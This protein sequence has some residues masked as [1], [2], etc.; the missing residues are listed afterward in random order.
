VAP[1]EPTPGPR[2]AR[3]LDKGHGRLEHR[4]LES[5]P[6]LTVQQKWPGLQQGFRVRRWGIR[7]G[8][9]YEEVV[10]GITSLAPEKADAERL[11]ELV[12]DHWRI[13]NSLHYI[14]DVTLGEDACQVRGDTAPQVLAALRNVAVHLL[15]QVDT[16]NHAQATRRLAAQP[17]QA[18]DLLS[19]PM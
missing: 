5:T 9:P 7:Q 1:K 18:I 11:L 3:T 17:Q 16:D 12:R 10:H 19:S 15:A 2:F 14:R 13:E 4:T 8:K 6:I